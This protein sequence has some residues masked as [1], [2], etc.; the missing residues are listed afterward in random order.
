MYI[1]HSCSLVNITALQRAKTRASRSWLNISG[2]HS[3]TGSSSTWTSAHIVLLDTD[4]DSTFDVL[5]TIGDWCTSG[6]I[7]KLE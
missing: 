4:L 3:I 1:I 5:L 6:L 2:P 7:N